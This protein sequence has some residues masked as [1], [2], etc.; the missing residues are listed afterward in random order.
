MADKG[1][2]IEGLLGDLGVER[3]RAAA[4][5]DERCT[6]LQRL[7]GVEYDAEK[8]D[9]QAFLATAVGVIEASTRHRVLLELCRDLNRRR[10]A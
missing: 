1:D 7:I 5:A 4:E 6:Q 2:I 3:D 9:G 8:F 10:M